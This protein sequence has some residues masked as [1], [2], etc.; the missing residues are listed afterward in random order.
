MNGSPNRS[1]SQ[2]NTASP[3]KTAT[4]FRIRASPPTWKVSSP[5]PVFKS[6]KNR[7]TSHRLRYAST[8]CAAS[9]LPLTGKLVS[10]HHSPRRPRAGTRQTTRWSRLPST[11]TSL[12]P[13]WSRTRWYLPLPS[14]PPP[15]REG[16]GK[17]PPSPENPPP[18]A[19]GPGRPAPRTPPPGPAPAKHLPV[20]KPPVRHIHQPPAHAPN[21]SRAA[22]MA[23]ST[24]LGRL[25]NPL[26]P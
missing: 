3:S 15:H 1:T 8:T 18:Q 16:P 2:R 12:H 13:K 20:V 24:S 22:S 10:S 14:A 21:R 26:S 25:A 5:S 9:S 7:S 4:T 19:S 23:P 11:S 17:K 6:R